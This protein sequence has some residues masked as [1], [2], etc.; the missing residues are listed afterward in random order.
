M[1]LWDGVGCALGDVGIL[2]LPSSLFH[3]Q[4]AVWCLSLP[5]VPVRMGCAALTLG[6]MA[7]PPV[8]ALCASAASSVTTAD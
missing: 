3:S 4:A 5:P 2:S 6:A 7:A 8:P 1:V